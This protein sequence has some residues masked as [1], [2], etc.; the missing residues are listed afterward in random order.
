MQLQLE[1]RPPYRQREGEHRGSD[2]RE[3]HPTFQ[4]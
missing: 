2:H 3:H 1:E 4:A